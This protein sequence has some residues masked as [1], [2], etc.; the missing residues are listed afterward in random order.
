LAKKKKIPQI[1]KQIKNQP[2]REMN[3][4]FE[5]AVSYSQ[6]SVFQSCPRKWSLQY[7]DGHYTS[8]QSIHMTF[9]TALHEA[10]QHYITTIYEVSG[11]AADRIDLKEYF[12]ERFRE[13]YLKDYKSNNNTHFSNS[14][15]MNEFFE[16][17][18]SILDFLKKRRNGYFGK[19][20]W[21]LIGCEL[22]LMVNPNPQY[23]NILYKGY[24]DVVLYNETF[25]KIKILDIKTS[26]KGWSDKEKK[27][28]VKQF[29]LILYK[30]FFAQQ[31]NVPVDDIEIEFFIVKRKIWENSDFPIPRIQEFK[32]ASGKV[33]LNKAYNAINEFIG[34]V[35][36]AD[37][38]HNSRN[39]LPQPSAH[40]CRFCPF[41]NNKELCDKGLT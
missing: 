41:K 11:A 21:H 6:F 17:G 18:L 8:E 25:N 39:H 7:R 16:D 10:I 26:T 30:K 20:G 2:L 1:V 36:N 13:T 33:K 27:D 14:I 40:N 37:G 31:F 15:E 24:L 3:Y 35:F 23:P 38:S 5:K 34:E 4:A 28:E 32:P 12:E 29:Q 9:G 19:K 22:P